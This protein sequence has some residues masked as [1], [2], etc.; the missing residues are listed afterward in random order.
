MKIVSWNVNGIRAVLKKDFAESF[1]SMEADI[2]C[3]QETKA[4]DDQV[5][6]ALAE[7]KDYHIYSNSAVKKGYSGTAIISKQAPLS[8]TK[9]MGIE[10]HDQEGR[11]LCAEYED[12]Y[13]VTVYVPNS[14]SELKRLDYRQTWDE[15][16]F[17]YL[18]NLEATKPVLVCGDFNV[19]HTEIDLARP[20]PNYNKSAGYMQEEIDGMDR[21]T[22]GGFKDTFRHFY[23]D[24]TDKYSWWSYRAGARGKNVGWRI[25]Y[26]LASEG[27]L[28]QLKGAFILNDIMGSDHC[29]VGIEL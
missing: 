3:L 6:E 21:F 28:P 27:F 1:A 15:D 17:N 25:D 7:F 18:K 13:L 5:K 29:P 4:Q 22:Q 10:E 19:A 12:F 11:V 8:I 24:V 20:K 14:G 2:L 23:P 16:F 9:D 26:F